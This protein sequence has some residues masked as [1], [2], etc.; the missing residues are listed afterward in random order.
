V[1]SP[2]RIRHPFIDARVSLECLL[3]NTTLFVL[4]GGLGIS[5]AGFFSRHIFGHGQAVASLGFPPR[6]ERHHGSQNA[7]HEGEG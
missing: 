7:D 3:S 1:W 2:E 4:P 6:P 5:L